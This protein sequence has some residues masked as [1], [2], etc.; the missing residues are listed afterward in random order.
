MPHN[1]MLNSGAIMSCALHLQLAGGEP[2]LAGRYDS[3]LAGLS[4]LA[5]GQHIGFNNAVF[6]SERQT[7]DRNFAMAYFMRVTETLS[8][9][10]RIL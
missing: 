1:P 3:L 9:T 6:L 5:G 8:I 7:A 4:R 10:A 2:G